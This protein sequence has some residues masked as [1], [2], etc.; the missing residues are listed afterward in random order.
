MDDNAKILASIKTRAKNLTCE[1]CGAQDWRVQEGMQA[2]V[3]ATDA[4]FDLSSGVPVHTV[5]CGNC[6][7][8]RLYSTQIGPT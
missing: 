4:G 3:T 2:L 6:G 1:S 8:L 5:I 7:F